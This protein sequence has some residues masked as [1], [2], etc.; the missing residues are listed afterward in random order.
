MKTPSK[1]E[2]LA[3][4]APKEDKIPEGWLTLR[5]LAEKY[6]LP[7]H[8]LRRRL[9]TLLGNKDYQMRYFYIRRARGL[10]KVPHYAPA[11]QTPARRSRFAADGRMP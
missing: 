5:Q 8:Q 7:E 4:S 10:A 1:A 11:L 3:L 9:A 6:E 2:F